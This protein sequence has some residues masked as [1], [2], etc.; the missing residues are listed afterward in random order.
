MA[1]AD[2]MSER[3]AEYAEVLTDSN[4]AQFLATESWTIQQD[5][6]WEQVWAN[7]EVQHRGSP[8]YL[9]IPRNN[10]LED[11]QLRLAQ[12][13]EA[14]GQAYGW[15]LPTIA[16]RVSAI[17]ADLFF[18]RVDQ[19][20][21]DGTIPLRQASELLES[22]DS[23]VRSA[24]LT[25]HNPRG[26]GK[27]R[28]PEYVRDFL[29]EDVRMGHTKRGSFIITVAA[30]LDTDELPGFPASPHDDTAGT[31]AERIFAAPPVEEPPV[32][33]P[34]ANYTRRVMTTLSRSLEVT[35]R[36]VVA[37][38]SSDELEEAV[39]QGMRLPLIKALR[40][41]GGGEGVRGLDLS[42]EWSALEPMWAD[43]PSEIRIDR[44]V[45]TS[46]EPVERQLAKRDEE[47]R[48]ETIVGA[49]VELKR[50][51]D[52]DSNTGEYEG[53]VVIQG[54]IDGRQ[55][56][57]TVPLHGDDY[58]WAIQAHRRRIPF[59]VSG[60]LEKVGRS[61]RLGGRVQADT[62][63]LEYVTKRPQD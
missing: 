59:T 45:L 57:V 39:A 2:S 13:V 19:S 60:R 61:W 8:M 23:M 44:E 32:E 40:T 5:L 10:R 26:T 38:G 22:I 11:Y 25:A 21:K 24:A 55:R 27:G 63:F 30:R 3:L 53:E 7:A 62:S 34:M 28:L 1:A 58:D 54:E 9:H 51:A 20:S 31:V 47:P 43:V 52:A 16:E 41:A 46:L 14:I 36:Y 12:A 37:G 35:Q 48:Q 49:V 18:V 42:F 4:V 29:A 50:A 56:R 17:R 15:T 6:G 33:E